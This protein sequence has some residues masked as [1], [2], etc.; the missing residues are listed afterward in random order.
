MKILAISHAC[1]LGVNRAVYR[2]WAAL[3]HEVTIVT[4]TRWGDA[5]H[6]IACEPRGAGDPAVVPLPLTG[7]SPRLYAFRGLGAVAD[8]FNPDIVLLD[9]DPVSRLALQM[10][11]RCRRRGGALCCISNENQSFDLR[12]SVRGRGML[13]GVATALPKLLVA[14]VARRVVDHVFTING[15]GL[16]MFRELGFPGVSKIPLGFD[17]ELFRPDPAARS[18]IRAELGWDGPLVAYFGRVVP[19]KGIHVLVQS[20]A[21]LADRPWRLLLDR[22]TDH[23]DAY[24]LGVAA[25]IRRLGMEQR[26]LWCNPAHSAIGAYMNAAD[27]V[28]VPS[29][30]TPQWKEQYGRVAQEAMACGTLVLASRSGALPELVGDGALLFDEGDEKALAALLGEVLSQPARF[31]GVRARGLARAQGLLS[32]KQQAAL[33]NEVFERLH[34]RRANAPAATR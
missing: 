14:C 28:V 2:E 4:A 27:V 26:V 22:F 32:V 24:A 7:R 12:S 18:R 15:D 31:D 16:A 10:G 34:R 29:L 23:G 17:P 8:R 11:F 20:M 13:T 9:N 33:M 25:Q 5:E 6:A 21:Q 30:S 19:G 1:V 3:G